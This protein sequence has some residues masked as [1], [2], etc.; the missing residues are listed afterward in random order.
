MKDRKIIILLL[1]VAMAGTAVTLCTAY[2]TGNLE[3]PGQVNVLL[4]GE[5]QRT[6]AGTGNA[7]GSLAADE[8]WT[9]VSGSEDRM[10]RAGKEPAFPEA[11]MPANGGS[12]AGGTDGIQTGSTYGTNGM[13]AGNAGDAAGM[14]AGSTYGA[15]GSP[16]GGTSGAAGI[17]TGSTYGTDDMP[18]GN[19]GGSA[20]MRTGSTYGADGMPAGGASSAAGIQTGSAYGTDAGQADGAYDAEDAQSDSAVGAAGIRAYGM[21]SIPVSGKTDAGDGQEGTGEVRADASG[22]SGSKTFQTGGSA[23]GASENQISEGGATESG[24]GAISGAGDFAGAEGSGGYGQKTGYNQNAAVDQGAVAG[25]GAAAG[26]EIAANQSAAAQGAAV[27][28]SASDTQG[29]ASNRSTAPAQKTANRNATA[30]QE[31]A[32]RSTA[33]AQEAAASQESGSGSGGDGKSSDIVQFVELSPMETT[34]AAEESDSEGAFESADF[35]NPGGG[36]SSEENPYL[37]RLT[38]LD[39]QIQ[40]SRENQNAANAGGAD[41]TLAKNIA[42]NELKLWDSELSTIYN[43][44]LKHLDEE[45]TQQLVVTERQWMKDRDAA[46]VEAAKSSAGGSLESVEY[47]SSQAES[48][49]ARA[50]ELAIRYSA[51]LME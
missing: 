42:G 39:A 24:Y 2:L 3:R 50:Y 35:E 14:Q 36:A 51:F 6:D 46:A 19:A 29:A 47:T 8:P 31:T 45:Q 17:Q 5:E 7:E 44:I 33:A 10:G 26:Q 23:S 37:L 11:G 30:A 49:R 12:S 43:T 34:A 27:N 28:R 32:N 22:A 9:G 4:A 21:I 13:A 18:A 38:E 1:C 41:N 48:T 20:G 40:K 25:Q 15:D 16:A